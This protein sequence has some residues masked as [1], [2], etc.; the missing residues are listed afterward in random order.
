MTI[1]IDKKTEQIIKLNLGC[2]DDTPDS[3]VNVDYALG[4]WIAK[5]PVFSA[6]NAKFKFFNLKW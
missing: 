5:I 4:A 3:W 1:S 2:G 6:I